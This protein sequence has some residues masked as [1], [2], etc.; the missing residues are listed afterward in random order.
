M[1]GTSSVTEARDAL[2]L[3]NQIDPPF[4]RDERLMVA[5]RAA[6]RDAAAGRG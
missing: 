1:Q 6:D 2:D 5:R 3:I 4:T